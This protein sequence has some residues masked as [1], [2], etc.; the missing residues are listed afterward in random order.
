M[1][2]VVMECIWNVC[3]IGSRVKEKTPKER[4]KKGIIRRIKRIKNEY[5]DN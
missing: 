5:Q 2:L 4:I 3:I 1:W